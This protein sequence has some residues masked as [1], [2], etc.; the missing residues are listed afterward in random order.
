MYFELSSFKFEENTHLVCNKLPQFV[1]ETENVN[2]GGNLSL[3]NIVRFLVNFCEWYARKYSY[4]C[5]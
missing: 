1:L 4:D 2:T 3:I 5:K